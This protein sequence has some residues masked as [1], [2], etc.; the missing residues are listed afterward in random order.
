MPVCENPQDKGDFWTNTC[1]LHFVVYF[2]QMWFY[3]GSKSAHGVQCYSVVLGMHASWLIHFGHKQHRHI[4]LFNDQCQLSE[5]QYTVHKLIKVAS[6]YLKRE[7]VS[8]S[9]LHIDI[10][11]SH[12]QYTTNARPTAWFLFF[13][14]FALKG[15]STITKRVRGTPRYELPMCCYSR[16]C[17]CRTIFKIY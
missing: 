6:G 8:P 9:W 16:P 7:L 2:V 3:W 13:S 12:F 15:E 4:S 11:N 14:S 1:P 10:S 5:S 17:Q